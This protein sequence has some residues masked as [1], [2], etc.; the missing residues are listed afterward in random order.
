D[1]TSLILPTLRFTPPNIYVL[2]VSSSGNLNF[3]EDKEILPILR[4]LASRAPIDVQKL[5]SL[6]YGLFE[7]LLMQKA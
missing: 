2:K 6:L 1:R 3:N 5:E 7:N 4:E